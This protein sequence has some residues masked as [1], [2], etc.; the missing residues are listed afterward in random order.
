MTSDGTNR[1]AAITSNG[2]MIASSR[3]PMTGRKSGMMSIGDIAQAM[4]MK[5]KALAK[6]GVRGSHKTNRW[7]ETSFR[8]LRATPSSLL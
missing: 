4:V 7:K 6:R 5:R 3:C 2:T 1:I 8:S